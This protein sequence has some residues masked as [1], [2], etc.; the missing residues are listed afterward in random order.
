[1]F[2]LIDTQ[3]GDQLLLRISLARPGI[4]RLPGRNRE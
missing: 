2:L 3:K 4:R 1:M